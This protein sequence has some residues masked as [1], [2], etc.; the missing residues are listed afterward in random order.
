[1]P[2]AIPSEK[3]DRA[4]RLTDSGVADGEVKR[5]TGISLTTI[6]KIRLR[7][8]RPGKKSGPRAMGAPD[9]LIGEVAWCAECGAFVSMPCLGCVRALERDEKEKARIAKKEEDRKA[10][11]KAMIAK[12]KEQNRRLLAQERRELARMRETA[13]PALRAIIRECHAKS[14]QLELVEELSDR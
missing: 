8:Y 2:S 4:R 7:T 1:M 5:L 13:G 14:F 10:R 11:V 9:N 12:I 6:R 3:I